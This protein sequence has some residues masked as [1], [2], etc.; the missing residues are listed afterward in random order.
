MIGFTIVLTRK[1]KHNIKRKKRLNF[2]IKK[3]YFSLAV[4]LIITIISASI[5]IDKKEGESETVKVTTKSIN[6]FREIDNYSEYYIPVVMNDFTSYKKGEKISNDTII[7][8]G[9][10][11]ILSKENKSEYE[12]FNGKLY[13]PATDV[14]ERITQ[15]FSKNIH[16]ENESVD[17][18][19]YSVV[20]EKSTDCYIVPVIGFSP[21]FTP[22]LESVTVK[23]NRTIL[24]VGCLRGENYKQD[25]SGNTVAPEAEKKILITLK[26]EKDGCHIEE[27]SEE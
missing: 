22:E 21:E 25:S 27:I 19:K 20:F 10:W 4:F 23:N 1:R 5:F 17:D 6:V 9:I 14:R 24:T 26:N 11:S 18:E 12:T 16:F 15:L 7:K 13:I 2:K 8:L 3:P